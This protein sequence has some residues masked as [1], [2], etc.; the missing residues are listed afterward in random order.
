MA[1]GFSDKLTGKIEAADFFVGIGLWSA[2]W[3]RVVLVMVVEMVVMVVVGLVLVGS[4]ELVDSVRHG[5][6]CC[7]AGN[8]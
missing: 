1:S 3:C 4:V 2:I 6:A 5:D 7:G 8:Q